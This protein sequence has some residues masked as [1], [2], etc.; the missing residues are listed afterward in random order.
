M[1]VLSW[2]KELLHWNIAQV[3]NSLSNLTKE[4]HGII[5][6]NRSSWLEEGEKNRKAPQQL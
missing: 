5:T 1:L 4:I 3:S 6:N 2:E